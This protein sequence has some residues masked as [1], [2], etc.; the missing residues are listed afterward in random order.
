MRLAYSTPPLLAPGVQETAQRILAA[1][2]LSGECEARLRLCQPLTC[3]AMVSKPLRRQT[4]EAAVSSRPALSRCSGDVTSGRDK[5]PLCVR[6][7]R[8]VMFAV[9][10]I[11]HGRRLK[12]PRRHRKPLCVDINERNFLYFTLTFFT[13]VRHLQNATDEIFL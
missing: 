7:T 9:W 4:L 13:F 5:H 8:G 2:R 11:T 1:S 10:G 12:G 3:V 6:R